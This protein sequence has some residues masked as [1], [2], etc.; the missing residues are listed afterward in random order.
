MKENTNNIP[1][2]ESFLASWLEGDISD[3]ELINLVSEVDFN[4][5]KKIKKGI[6]AL[7]ALE[8]PL[9]SSNKIIQKKKQKQKRQSLRWGISIAAS[10]LILFGIFSTFS[11][12]KTKMETANAE[13]KSIFLLDGSE[14]ILNATS[15][16]TYQEEEWDSNRIVNLKG[17]AFFKVKKGSTF[18][19]QTEYG[20]I[21]VLGTQFNVNASSDYFEVTCFEGKVKVIHNDKDFILNPSNSFRKINGNTIEEFNTNTL[22]P[23]WLNGESSFKSVPLK[24]VIFALEKQYNIKID[25]NTIDDSLIFTGSFSHKDLEIALASVFKTVNINYKKKESGIYRLE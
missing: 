5:Y 19:V 2:N 23:T 8:Q 9:S 4:T 6:L 3:K 22:S 12:P 1:E 7:E 21:T 20:K 18:T 16:I 14:V 13:Q 25:A 17:E 11:N 24:Y 15:E 10:L